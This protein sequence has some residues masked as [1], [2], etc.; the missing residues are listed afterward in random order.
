M[1][2]FSTEGSFC[3]DGYMDHASYPVDLVDETGAIIGTKERAAIDKR[4]DLYH[5]VFVLLRTPDEKL[6][7]GKIPVRR[8]LPNLY[9][10]K[11]GFT[12]ATIRRHDELADQA[13]KRA[14]GKELGIVGTIPVHIKDSYI[15]L[16]DGHRSYV[17]VYVAKHTMPIDF[18]R[19]DIANLRAF[20]LGE[21]DNEL[22]THPERFAP[23]FLELWSTCRKGL[24]S[25]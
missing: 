22:T 24:L 1:K 10:E 7:L 6:V 18:T 4:M 2:G 15:Y 21:L 25:A 12:A 17:S 14:L 11:F 20:S 9:S 8:D 3:Y 16:T 23:T 19:T 5:T 13:S